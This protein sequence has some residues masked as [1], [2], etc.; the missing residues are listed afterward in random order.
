MITRKNVKPNV[1]TVDLDGPHG[2][3]FYLI[4]LA[5]KLAKQLD[6][7]SPVPLMV[8]SKNYV[9]AVSIMNNALG[10]VIL[11]ETENEELFNF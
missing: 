9:E 8:A 7:E 5:A 10:D 3:V 6:R 4:G 2:N 11:F 1:I